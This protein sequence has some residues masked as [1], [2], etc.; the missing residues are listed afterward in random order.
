MQLQIYQ[1][2]CFALLDQSKLSLLFLENDESEFIGYQ[3][4]EEKCHQMI[5]VAKEMFSK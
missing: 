5:K 2:A 3:T 4:D 1:S